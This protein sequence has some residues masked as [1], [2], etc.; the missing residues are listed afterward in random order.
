MKRIIPL[1]YINPN[2]HLSWQEV[3]WGYYN[4][5]FFLRDV[6][7]MACDFLMCGGDNKIIIELAGIPFEMS[8]S[9]IYD[10]EML[11]DKLVLNSPKEDGKFIKDKWLYLNLAWLFEHRAAFENIFDEAY[12]IYCDFDYPSEISSFFVSYMP[13]VGFATTHSL[14]D[15]THM[16]AMNIWRD[17]LERKNK[18]F[19]LI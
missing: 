14:D 5:Y 7:Q 10:A 2:M 15:M 18:V 8:K 11:L 9:D 6:V 17:Y 19:S 1:E 16:K 13:G 12:D 4:G 3:A